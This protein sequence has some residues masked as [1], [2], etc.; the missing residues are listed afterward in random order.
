M[1]G[2]LT[3]KIANL[4]PTLLILDVNGVGYEV[5]ITINTYDKISGQTVVSL[6]IVTI[7]RE[8]SITL[9]GF[10]SE[11][12][13]EMFKLLISVSGIG[14]KSA[15]SILSGIRV[16][17]LRDAIIRGDI[18]RLV[19]AP[20][21]GKKTAERVILELRNKAGDIKTSGTAAPVGGFRSEA[22]A[23]L[24]TLGYNQRNAEKTVS[25]LLDSKPDLS[26]EELIKAALK[27]FS[28]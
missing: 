16:E 4:K 21:I 27:K 2:Y 17:D 9:F 24:V 14:P 18:S 8:D 6:Y 11:P 22:I 19:T 13:K 1:I 23:A 28:G 20:G 5:N 7:V 26:L 10:F 25:D 15:Q 12:E 3:G